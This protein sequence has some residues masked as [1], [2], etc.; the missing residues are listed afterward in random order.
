[1]AETARSA[2]PI[3]NELMALRAQIDVL[4]RD[5]V[6]LLNERARL[7]L[8]V[9]RAKAA[10]GWTGVRDPEREVEVLARVAEINPGPLPERDLLAVYRRLVR[11]TRELELRERN[12][13]SEPNRS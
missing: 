4:D 2:D 9:G 13:T 11:A 10:A 12:G 5:I 8:A 7:G 1:M 6:E 3:P